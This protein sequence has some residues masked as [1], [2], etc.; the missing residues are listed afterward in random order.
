MSKMIL[1][2]GGGIDS[3]TLLA[4]LTKE[5]HEVHSVFFRYGQKAQELEEQACRYFCKLYESQLLVLDVP[6]TSISDSTIMAGSSLANDPSKNILDGRNLAL[7]SITSILAAKLQITDIAMGYHVEPVARPF[8]DASIEFVH[9]FNRMSAYAFKHVPKIVAPFSEWT[10]EQIFLWAKENA[11][12]ILDLAHTCYEDVP[13]GCGQ[14]SHCL[15]KQDI[16][17]K[18]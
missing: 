5:G 17:E 18:L 2:Y 15:L 4:Y 13:G 11:P 6:L 9:A 1:L 16:L 10:R 14:C 8:P 3:S 12:E 7:V